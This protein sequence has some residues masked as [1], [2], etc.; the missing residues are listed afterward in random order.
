MRTCNFHHFHLYITHSS[1]L[2]LPFFILCTFFSVFIISQFSHTPNHSSMDHNNIHSPFRSRYSPPS[3]SPPTTPST[4]HRRRKPS[5]PV[6]FKPPPPTMTTMKVTKP[7]TECGKTFWSPKALFGHMRCH[8]EREWRGIN[9][10]PNLRRRRT[11][12]PPSADDREVAAS[13]LLLAASSSAPVSWFEC[14][15]CKKTFPS[16]QALGGHRASHKNVKGCFA[17]D[18]E[19]HNC[20]FNDNGEVDLGLGLVLGL[21]HK[22]WV[23]FKVFTSGQALGGHMRCH[24]DKNEDGSTSSF[25]LEPVPRPIEA[26]YGLD[27]NLPAHVMEEGA[28]H[29][30][31]CSTSTLQ[32]DLRLGI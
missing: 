24:W 27:L 19:G 6:C 1:P 11:S 25:G 29:H 7:C 18:E 23:C 17:I 5:K 10:P 8:P 15:S 26:R 31:I 9:P 2:P 16:H 30:P 21:A 14:S 12:P 22:C 32:L 3:F 13:L 28:V 4:S 20:H